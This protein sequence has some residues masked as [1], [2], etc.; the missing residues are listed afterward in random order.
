MK[1]TKQID[2][3]AAA[4]TG[5]RGVEYQKIRTAY[6]DAVCSLANLKDTLEMADAELGG[7]T[8]LLKE[9]MI[10]IEAFEAMDRSQLGRHL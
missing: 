5:L 4:L 10:A 2:P 9:H 8:P 1:T 3:L 7:N 6:Y